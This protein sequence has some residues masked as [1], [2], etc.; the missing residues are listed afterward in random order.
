MNAQNTIFLNHVF[1][2]IKELSYPRRFITPKE[3]GTLLRKCSLRTTHA[4]YIRASLLRLVGMQR[5]L[6]PLNCFLYIRTQANIWEP[7]LQVQQATG[8]R[9]LHSQ[10]LL[11]MSREISKRSFFT[12]HSKS[13]FLVSRSSSGTVIRFSEKSWIPTEW[14]VKYSTTLAVWLWPGVCNVSCHV[15]VLGCRHQILSLCQ[16]HSDCL[17]LKSVSDK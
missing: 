1:I 15:H 3:L 9:H 16:E 12:N 4:A 2:Y 10:Q 11:E 7:S 8:S 5:R 13:P 17:R 14:G 6:L